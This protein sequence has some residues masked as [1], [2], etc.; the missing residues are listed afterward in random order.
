MFAAKPKG[1]KIESE[2][3]YIGIRAQ[4]HARVATYS[5]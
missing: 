3:K 4:H 2:E 1:K 5:K